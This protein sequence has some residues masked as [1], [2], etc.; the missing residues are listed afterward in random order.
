M[1]GVTE[2]DAK[3][4]CQSANGYEAGTTELC[5]GELVYRDFVYD[6]HGADTGYGGGGVGGMGVG[7]LSYADHGAEENVADLLELRLDLDGDT[8][9]VTALLNTLFDR[10]STQVVVAVNTDAAAGGGTWPGYGVRS[11][12]WDVLHVLAH[13]RP[14]VVVD[15][16]ANKIV[17]T[18]PV[19]AGER[20]RVQAVTALADGTVAN[21][22]FRSDEA[23]QFFDGVQ[24]A[25]LADGDISAFG[26][27]VDVADLRAGVTRGQP[28]RTGL[29]ERVYVSEYPMGEGIS[30]DGR[31]GR[32][33]SG[34]GLFAQVFNWFGTHQPYIVYVPEGRGPF[35]VQLMLH[36]AGGGMGSI[37]TSASGGFVE[38]FGDGLE[39]IVVSPLG[40]GVTSL[41]ADEAERDVLDVLDDVLSAYPVDANR[42]VAGGYS[43]GGYGT[44]RLVTHHPDRFAGYLGW[45]PGTGDCMNG[46]PL[47]SGD[48][49]GPFTP[50]GDPA[51]LQCDDTG[52]VGNVYDLLANTRHVPGGLLFA[53]ADELVWANHA[54][55]LTRRLGELGYEHQVWTH[56]AAEHF[57]FAVLDDWD[58]E[59]AWSSGWERVRAVG[60]VTYRVDQSLE[61][62][63]LGIT[64]RQAY[65]ISKLKARGRGYVGV[66]LVGGCG[67]AEQATTSAYDAGPNPV[68][69]VS[70]RADPTGTRRVTAG[71]TLTGSLENVASL[72]I[73][74]DAACLDNAPVDLSGITTDGPTTIHFTDG[75]T[76]A[77]TSVH[78]GA[79]ALG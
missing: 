76:R 44:F 56:P 39:R 16:E 31:P 2:V 55:A 51:G 64:Y 12:G 10:D 48:Q 11:A 54:V 20:W 41:Y 34:A 8:L 5:A 70:K 30:L 7:N 53:G 33:T 32:P 23:G 17:G 47:A 36:G 1:L 6:D 67:I 71:N 68:P 49:R 75:T 77:T 9:V 29:R 63:D 69:W 24:A 60:R 38:T 45:V 78:G 25:A 18:F 73:D 42:V 79:P 50:L 59:A 21:V 14:G 4:A 58:K 74:A 3:V 22:A 46:T 40:R 72:V 43:M 27:G 62:P 66:D 61:R 52:S 57:T 65:W 19:P 15:V 26:A 28:L 37:V 13:D 35:G